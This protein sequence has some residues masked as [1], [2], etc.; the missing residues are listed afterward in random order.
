MSATPNRSAARRLRVE[1]L[2]C[3][4]TPHGGEIGS[5]FGEIG[6]MVYAD[7]NENGVFDAGDTALEGVI[8]S[9]TN[10]F[11]QPA[12]STTTDIDGRYKFEHLNPGSYTIRQEQPAGYTDGPDQVGTVNGFLDGQL[13]GADEIANICMPDCGVGAGYNFTEHCELP[14]PP[15]PPPPPV[16]TTG[17]Q[18]LTPGFWKNNAVKHDG[19]AWA[20]TGYF[21]YQTLGSVFDLAGTQYASLANKTL[22]QALSLEGGGVNALMRHAVAGLLNAGHT[23]VDY[24]LTTDQIVSKVNAALASGSASQIESLKNEL[25]GYNNLGANL[26]QHGRT[27]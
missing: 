17:R 16:E 23:G 4:L 15:P 24:P 20:D 18:G 13:N 22:V 27:N 8:L 14:P 11:G 26:D 2:E 25:D 5:C 10:E 19:S 1:T 7:C 3:R 21:M 12:G 6:G 9:L